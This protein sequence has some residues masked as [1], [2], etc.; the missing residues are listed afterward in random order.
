[1][2]CSIYELCEE[3]SCTPLLEARH[4]LA[5]VDHMNSDCIRVVQVSQ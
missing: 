5:I 1:M 2:V 3:A 4:L